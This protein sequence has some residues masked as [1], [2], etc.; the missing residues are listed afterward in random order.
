MNPGYQVRRPATTI[1]KATLHDAPELFEIQRQATLD[2]YPNESMGIT[3]QDVQL[4]LE[5]KNGQLI[6]E[7]IERW[8]RE[9][10]SA[11][12]VHMVWT[13]QAQNK[14]VGFV[15]AKI[16]QAGQHRV[17]S[18]YVL[19]EF[20]GRGVGRSLIQQA[21]DWHGQYV[22]I[23]LNVLAYNHRARALYKKLGFQPTDREMQDE[24]AK[25][26]NL[27]PL[28]RIEMCRCHAKLKE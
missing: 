1:Q 8:K 27:R 23:Y 18:L 9:I 10:T 22:D 7:G 14:I 2:A 13:A 4:R 17:E 19:P 11:R 25:Q 6:P 12:P 5:G 20:Q 24:V 26:H 16:T 28:P 15:V 3:R 21:L